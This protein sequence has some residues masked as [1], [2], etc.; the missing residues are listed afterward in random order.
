MLAEWG[1]RNIDILL[2]GPEPKPEV[3]SRLRKSG[4][5]SEKVRLRSMWEELATLDNKALAALP[6]AS[7][8]NVSAGDTAAGNRG[9]ICVDRRPDGSLVVAG[10]GRLPLSGR[11]I[12][13]HDRTG[14]A[15]SQWESFAKLCHAWFDQVFGQE[16]TILL[17]DSPVTG[18]IVHNYRR[19]HVTVLQ[20]FH[21]NHVDRQDISKLSPAKGKFF[22]LLTHTDHLDRFITLTNAQRRDMQASLIG[23]DNLATVPN[24]FVGN[25]HH[26]VMPRKRGRGLITSRLVPL[27][28]L[29]HAVRIFA[30]TENRE[31]LTLE[32]YGTGPVEDNLKILA[33]ELGLDDSIIFHGFDPHARD[34]Y[35]DSSFTLMTSTSE[36]QG[37]VLLEAMAAGCVP[38]AYD[39]DYGPSDIITDGID[40]FLVPAGDIGAAA[41]VLQRFL[42]M[43]ESQVQAMR[44]AAVR[45]AADFQSDRVC[46]AWARTFRDALESKT[47]PQKVRIRPEAHT[48]S[49]TPAGLQVEISVTGKDATSLEWALLTWVGR[50]AEAYGRVR[51]EIDPQNRAAR[52]HGILPAERLTQLLHGTLDI[53]V[54]VRVR[55]T[56]AR[57]RIKVPESLATPNTDKMTT[58]RTVKGN[59]SIRIATPPS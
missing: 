4:L 19:S 37:L 23:T 1:D 2:T 18:G 50:K 36:G 5:I 32:V 21:N 3:T 17:S 11:T 9:G 55:G 56:A 30:G 22:E 42:A 39:I 14:L 10:S 57:R 7:A 52:L 31:S 13:L 41:R 49:M 45:R 43:N 40:G 25:L 29:D 38:I 54:D 46:E 6:G 53:Y 24:A 27:K 12:T 34:A 26:S 48:L 33:S 16:P 20:A 59:L 8:P 15:V 47:K 35:A 51:A 28:R 44:E 58:F